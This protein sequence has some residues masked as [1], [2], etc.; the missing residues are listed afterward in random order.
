MKLIKKPI[1]IVGCGFAGIS[2]ALN[3]RKF[4]LNIPIIIIDS[5]SSFVFKPLMYEVLSGEIRSWEVAPNLESIFANSGI[6]FLKNELREINFSKNILKFKDNLNIDYQYLVLSTGSSPNSFSI[7]GVD[8]YC[9]FFNDIKDISKLKFFLEQDSNITTKEN[10]FVIGAGPSG[11]ELALKL[12]DI[13]NHKFNVQIIEKSQHILNKNKVFNRE[14]AE[15]AIKKKNIDLMLNT[16]VVEIRENEIDITDESHNRITLNHHA[17]IWTAGVKPN[18]PNFTE[19]VPKL[20]GKLL[21]NENLQIK[22]FK[23]TFALGDIS[24]I[25]SKEDLPSTAQVA[26]QQGQ[27]TAN[28]LNLL[29]Q[30]KELLPFEFKDNGEMISLG[31]GEASISALGLTLSG[32]FA[33]ELRR[34]I[35]ASKM[36]IIEKSFKSAASWLIDKKSIFSK[37]ITKN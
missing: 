31:L 19:E 6:T 29:I 33:F 30:Q 37:I 9:Y 17:V 11:V 18:L 8:E 16:N 12:S 4:D 26:M 7:K 15:K 10:I 23:N 22:G 34:L 28:N 25:E 14:E 3:L 1:V 13:Y 5:R 35:Y 32:K 36:P 24:V 2:T 21:I 27:H 20:L